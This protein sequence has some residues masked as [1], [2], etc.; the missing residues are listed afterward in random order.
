MRTIPVASD[1]RAKIDGGVAVGRGRTT[2]SRKG[3]G[4][5]NKPR[6]CIN[7]RLVRVLDSRRQFTDIQRAAMVNASLCKTHV[8]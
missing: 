3:L 4:R 8:Q 6:N 7:R 5:P 2:I 1:A